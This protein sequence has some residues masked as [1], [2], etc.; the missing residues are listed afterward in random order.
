MAVQ[1]SLVFDAIDRACENGFGDDMRTL[2]PLT[3]AIDICNLDS[4]FAE[5]D[6]LDLIPHIVA[7]RRKSKYHCD[8]CGSGWFESD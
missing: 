8:D 3:V 6:P 4:D 2:T 1:Q 7:W 5:T